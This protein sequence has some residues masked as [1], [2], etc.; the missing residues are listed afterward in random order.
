MMEIAQIPFVKHVGIEQR[1]EHL[2]LHPAA[3][4]QNHIGTLHAGAI[5]TLAETASGMALMRYFPELESEVTALLRSSDIRYKSPAKT[6][7]YTTA[8][9]DK[10]EAET[11]LKRLEK[12]GRASV[13][14]HVIVKDKKKG[15][16][17][18]ESIFGWFVIS[19]A[20]EVSN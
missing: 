1:E 3:T 4:L 8:K 2:C 10:T 12:R 15:T 18:M 16:V 17:V 11:F 14:V 20:A 5:Y 19:N 13:N 9:I 7:L 6:T